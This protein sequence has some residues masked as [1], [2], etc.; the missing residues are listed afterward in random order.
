MF[1]DNISMADNSSLDAAGDSLVDNAVLSPVLG[2]VENQ[3]NKFAGSGSA[4]SDMEQIYGVR[5][6]VAIQNLLSDMSQGD[7]GLLSG[8]KIVP[9]EA[10]NG[11][12]GAYASAQDAIY[13]AQSLVTGS[14]PVD[15]LAEVVIEEVGHRIDEL[16]NPGAD[17]PG[18][19][20]EAFRNAVLDFSVSEAEQLRI[21]S[22]DDRG[23]VL[24]DEQVISVE[25]ANFYSNNWSVRASNAN[26]GSRLANLSYSNTR[27]DGKQGFSAD[28]GR[29]SPNSRIPDDFFMLEMWT[30]TEFEAGDTYRFQFRADDGYALA[31]RPVNGGNWSYITEWKFNEDAYGG[32]TIEFTPTSDGD[33]WVLAYFRERDG[34]AYF[35]VSWENVSGDSFDKNYFPELTSLSDDDW[36]RQTSDNTGF[37]Y[38]WPD[39]YRDHNLTSREVEQI[40]TDL[41]YDLFGRGERFPMTAGYMDPGYYNGDPDNDGIKEWHAGIDIGATTGTRVEAVAPGTVA[42][43]DSGFI[44]VTSQTGL[45]QWVYGHLNLNPSLSRGD[46][47][48][49]ETYLGRINADNHLHFETRTPDGFGGT[50]GAHYNKDFIKRATRSPLQTYWFSRG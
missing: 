4:Q 6:P 37:D 18:D 5:D 47:I 36:D 15:L 14:G 9:D 24:L 28:W 41:N 10:M 34:D 11:A 20:G 7:T 1:D 32:K 17:T 46:R 2:E 23:T 44:G 25:Q 39:Y 40:Y 50:G 16:L 33:H 22:E 49:T 29:G 38:G 8:I 26:T 30:Q 19:E 42:W 45:S 27:S 43:I 35:D 21:Q 31:T 12:Q 3:L 48:D 13:L